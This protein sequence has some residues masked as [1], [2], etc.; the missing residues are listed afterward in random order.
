MNRSVVGVVTSGVAGSVVRAVSRQTTAGERR[1][2]SC[3]VSRVMVRLR[4]R[5]VNRHVKEAVDRGVI[6]GITPG[7]AGGGSV[8]TYG[9]ESQG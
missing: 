7:L 8:T 2:V 3:G 5:A 4:N 1:V 6:P 9:V